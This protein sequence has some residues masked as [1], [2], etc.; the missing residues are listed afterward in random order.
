MLKQDMSIKVIKKVVTCLLDEKS[1]TYVLLG[2]GGQH[3][4]PVR[5]VNDLPEKKS[6]TIDLKRKVKITVII[7]QQYNVQ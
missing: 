1:H 3:Q 5:K 4:C 2:G 6:D 7:C